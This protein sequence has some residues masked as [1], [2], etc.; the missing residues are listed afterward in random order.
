MS[1]TPS[2]VERIKA[3]SRH[4]RGT[5]E[6]SLEDRL[7]GAIADD[8]TQL[9]KFHG[10]YQQDDRDVRSERRRQRLEPAYSFMIRARVPGGV[11]TPAQWLAMDELARTHANGTLRL[12]T[13]QA[14]QFHGVIKTRLRATI[15]GIN[16]CLLDTLAACGDVNRNVMA[17]VNPWR[18]ALHARVAAM[19]DEVSAHLTPATRAYHDIWLDGEKLESDRD[20]QEP[21]YGA[22]YLPR[23]FKMGFVVPPENDIDVYSQDLGFI[24]IEESGELAGFNVVVGGGMGTTHGEP[25]TW[26]RLG[27]VI[28]YCTPE[29]V[30][31]VSEA[32][33]TTQRDFGD[34]TNRKH[35]RLKYTIEDRGVDWFRGEV[36]RRA[37]LELAPP[38][39][40]RFT[41]TGDRYGW[42]EGDDGLWHRTLFIE[43][44]RVADRDSLSL[45]TALREVAAL[46]RGRFIL[47]P[48]QNVTLSG[49]DDGD[50]ERV[51]EILRRHGVDGAGSPSVLRSHS[52]ACVGLP[53]C[54]LAMAESERY[55]PDLV[56]RLEE[57]L[58]A[59][60]LDDEPI[61]IRM[62]G[63]PNGCARPYLAEI[64]LVGK[65]PGR[66][67]LYLGAGFSGD[68]LNRL[69]RENI[70]EETILSELD[71]LFAR[72]AA[73]R[74]SGER[75]GD[76]L[77]RAGVI[78]AVTSGPDFRA[79][80]DKVA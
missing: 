50:R 2:D 12:T 57:R 52:L 40:F 21:I 24:A 44:G 33:V 17:G 16:E 5:L 43:N 67:N 56:G 14:F 19:A 53:T 48:N 49:L 47:T 29:Q 8:D 72:Y 46:G 34:R 79:D 36:E 74:D 28:G 7:T 76:F 54:A 58:A 39:P 73:E 9:S 70:D 60:G 55:L 4:L 68:R 6:Q 30:V 41:S 13:R 71:G 31:A 42:I 18:S 37:G 51:S 45:M 69:H 65:A 35:A 75:F 20:E 64:G 61:V 78:R 1:G 32:V 22:T 10:I 62:T 63:C 38:R 3:G 77:V 15:R 66:Y 26:P 23:K 59:H 80:E 27:D 11:C 25:D